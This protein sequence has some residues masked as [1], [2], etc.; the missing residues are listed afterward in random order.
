MLKDIFILKYF[1]EYLHVGL[2][3]EC[4]GSTGMHSSSV[5]TDLGPQLVAVSD[6]QRSTLFLRQ[7]I[8][9]S[10]QSLLSIVIQTYIP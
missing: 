6:E 2:I 3:G 4:M 8:D 5:V 10:L 1:I 7:R 9:M